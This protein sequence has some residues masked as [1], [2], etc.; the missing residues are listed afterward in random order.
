MLADSL[1][2]FP[3]LG[4]S[5]GEPVGGAMLGRQLQAPRPDVLQSLLF[6]FVRTYQKVGAAIQSGDAADVAKLIPEVLRVIGAVTGLPTNQ[7]IKTF[8]YLLGDT[9]TEDNVGRQVGGI[10][11]GRRGGSPENPFQMIG[12]AAQGP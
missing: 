11:Y 10:I 12:D 1:S 3:L 4:S 7:S 6:Q 5:I 9:A 8:G 2:L